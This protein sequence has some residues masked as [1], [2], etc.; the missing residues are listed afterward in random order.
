MFTED[1]PINL[2]HEN[3]DLEIVRGHQTNDEAKK[4]AS[5][6]D[7]VKFHPG[8]RK[9]LKSGRNNFLCK[10]FLTEDGKE[11]ARVHV[12]FIVNKK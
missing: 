4:T 10:T 11:K 5:K 3:H 2:D 1:T 7:T 8:F 9:L 12:P 6:S